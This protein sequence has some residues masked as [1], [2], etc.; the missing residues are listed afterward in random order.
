[1]VILSSSSPLRRHYSRNSQPI[2]STLGMI[3]YLTLVEALNLYR[4]IIEQS[5]GALGVRDL[6]D[7]SD[8]VAGRSPEL[9][10]KLF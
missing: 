1:M 4:Q 8:S 5:G 3:R 10:V 9:G 2:V 6:G 7:E